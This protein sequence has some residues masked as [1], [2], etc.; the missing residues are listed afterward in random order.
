M[1][2][3]GAA[4]EELGPGFEPR[5]PLHLS[6][7]NSGIAGG[8]AL[9]GFV[10]QPHVLEEPLACVVAFVVPRDG[11]PL[12]RQV[13]REWSDSSSVHTATLFERGDEPRALI[14]LRDPKRLFKDGTVYRM[15]SK[16]EAAPA[17]PAA[18]VPPVETPPR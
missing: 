12:R 3:N 4:L 9:A 2:R 17:T 18:A 13:R 11:P 10:R 14:G 7:P 5:W 6:R 1:L 15:H 8:Q 16:A